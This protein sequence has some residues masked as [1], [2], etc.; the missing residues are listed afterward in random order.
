MAEVSTSM[1]QLVGL[2]Q[3]RGVVKV[4]DAAKEL[5]TDKGH[6]ESW[7]K[8]L[9]KADAIEVHYSVIGGALLKKG[10]KF[11]SVVRGEIV[12][13]PVATL[14]P[15]PLTLP[16]SLPRRPESPAQAAA[17]Y[18]LIRKKLE[19][20]E[21]TLETDLRKLY[22]E[23]AAVVQYMS[24]VVIEGKKIAEYIETLKQIVERMNTSVERRLPESSQE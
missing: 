15:Q 3:T 12:C 2:L 13:V 23:Q 8:M 10:P 14:R 21:E 4:T 9:E 24:E 1:D 5:G 19:E 7:A 16:T 20:E 22:E 6:I 18:A 11:D 17:E